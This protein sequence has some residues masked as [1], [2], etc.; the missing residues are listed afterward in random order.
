[1]SDP[2]ASSRPI[3]SSLSGTMSGCLV[4]DEP[5]STAFSTGVA[6]DDSSCTGEPRVLAI[7]WKALRSTGLNGG[8]L[9][10][11]GGM[12]ERNGTTFFEGGTTVSCGRSSQL[13]AGALLAA[14]AFGASG[15]VSSRSTSCAGR[16]VCLL[17]GGGGRLAAVMAG[18]CAT[19]ADAP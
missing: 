8:R 14:P 18:R 17:A 9:S 6:P 1:W 3:V 10:G 12:P 5:A 19:S 7:S 15:G 4:P 11:T 16:P 13:P 2:P